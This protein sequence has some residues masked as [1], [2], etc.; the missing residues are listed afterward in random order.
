MLERDSAGRGV[1]ADAGGD[2]CDQES[3]GGGEFDGEFGGVY[4]VSFGRV[5]CRRSAVWL[6]W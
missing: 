2:D 6:M 5:R 3:E 1:S 4:A